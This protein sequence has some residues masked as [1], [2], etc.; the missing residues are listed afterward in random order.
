MRYL[1]MDNS[2]NQNPTNPSIENS[3]L[4]KQYQDILD[5]YSKE[6]APSETPPA[7]D[8]E[9]AQPVLP[10]LPAPLISPASTVSSLPPMP[11]FESI[12]PVASKPPSNIFKYLFFISLLIFLGVLGTIVY[13]LFVAKPM[14][15]SPVTTN[16]A[17]V[18]VVTPTSFEK[19]C[20]ANGQK[21]KIGENFS[22]ADGCN[23]CSCGPDL[24]I[25]CTL[26]AC[27]ATPSVKLTPTIKV[28]P[29][30][31]DLVDAGPLKTI[32]TSI[33]NQLRTNY[34]EV[35]L[36]NVKSWTVNLTK[37]YNKSNISAIKKA[38]VAAGLG[39]DPS[40]SGEAGQDWKEVYTHAADVC[41]LSYVQSVLTL[42]CGN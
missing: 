10:T 40:S 36:D 15:T 14:S 42:S 1:F 32:L 5:R 31:V 4:A 11:V 39:L 35:T 33:N 19:F 3:D 7:L 12:A 2:S 21:F 38:I 20:E 9:P 37:S 41:T 17:V 34:K 18:E 23:T 16:P 22:A 29:T 26:K 28:T 6:L 25:A 27:D 30:T 24:T 13:T 8:Q